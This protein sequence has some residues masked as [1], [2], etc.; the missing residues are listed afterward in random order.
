MNSIEYNRQLIEIDNM[1]K[2]R[3]EQINRKFL[4]LIAAQE[5]AKVVAVAATGTTIDTRVSPDVIRRR[6][7]Q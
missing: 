2:S 4:A 6:K 3:F 7:V 1:K 5:Y